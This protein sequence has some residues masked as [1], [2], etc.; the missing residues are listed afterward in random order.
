MQSQR[1][2]LKACVSASLQRQ[3]AWSEVCVS[4]SLQRQDVWSEVRVSASL[5]KSKRRVQSSRL[6]FAALILMQSSK[7]TSQHHCSAKMQDSK[8]ASRHHCNLKMQS[9]KPASSKVRSR[10]PTCEARN[11]YFNYER[12]LCLSCNCPH[13]RDSYHPYNA[14]SYTHLTL[15]TKRIV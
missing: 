7:L 6:H 2:G 13:Y 3:D 11:P 15:P 5:H 10:H 1:T 4:A 14:V 9:P 8:P 12:A